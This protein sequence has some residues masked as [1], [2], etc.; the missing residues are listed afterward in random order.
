MSLR[1]GRAG[2]GTYQYVQQLPAGEEHTFYFA[3]TLS[4][5]QPARWPDTGVIPYPDVAAPANLPPVD[6]PAPPRTFLHRLYL[7]QIRR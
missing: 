6:P 2:H 7:P 5:G 4:N 1:W 3:F